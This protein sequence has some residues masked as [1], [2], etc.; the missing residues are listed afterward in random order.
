MG[1][2]TIEL[3]ASDGHQLAAYESRPEQAT[4]AVVIAQEIFGLNP[5]IRSVVDRYAALGFHAIAPALFTA[6]SAHRARLH[7]RRRRTRP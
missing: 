5:H 7:V 6:S 2:A 1:A 3:T 4:A